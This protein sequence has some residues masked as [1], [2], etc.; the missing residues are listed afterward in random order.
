M[1]KIYAL[2]AGAMIVSGVS[3]ATLE[4]TPKL[5]MENAKVVGQLD[6]AALKKVADKKKVM[7]RADESEIPAVAG[8]YMICYTNYSKTNGNTTRMSPANSLVPTDK[9][10]EYKF[11]TFIFSDVS[12]A[13]NLHY[14]PEFWPDENGNPVGEWVLSVPVGE[15]SEPIFY[16]DLSDYSRYG[17][18]NNEPI[19]LYLAGIDN[20]GEIGYYTNDT[21][22]FVVRD[23]WLYSPYD[24][25]VGFGMASRFI[26]NVG[27]ITFGAAY[28]DLFTALPNAHGT[29][30]EEA[31]DEYGNPYSEEIEF[32]MYTETYEEDGMQ[33]W[34]VKGF[35][36]WPGDVFFALSQS[37]AM[38]YTVNQVLTKINDYD[39]FMIQDEESTEVYMSV[40]PENTGKTVLST[41]VVGLQD[42]DGDLWVV[43][44]DIVVTLD[45]NVWTGEIL[46]VKNPTVE[47]VNAPAVYYNMQGMQVAN[48]N[49][50][51]LYIVKKGD[52]VSKQIIK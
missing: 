52:K 10:G 26:P 24:D 51:Q 16:E 49:A 30:V 6:G 13:A 42:T 43:Y 3:A 12:M 4:K 5:S 9:E 40:T 19:Y 20:K 2:L 1:K 37:E 18:T 34:F 44:S 33:F 11:E 31:A 8:D 36:G 28:V 29:A 32:P 14:D 48:P 41:E 25:V 22:E 45:Y 50:G 27:G 21:Y 38:A 39:L 15:T 7:S 35:C 46:G 47:D 23:G 17:F